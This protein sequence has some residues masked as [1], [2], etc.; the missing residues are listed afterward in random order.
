MV[1]ASIKEK[2][3]IPEA[4]ARINYARN[5]FA[6]YV[7]TNQINREELATVIGKSRQYVDKL[8]AG[9]EKGVAAQINL[10]KLMEYTQFNGDNFY[11][12][13]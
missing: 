6:T 12:G 3:T 13:R 4:W 2:L 10:Q 1:D 7:K 8:L 9:T 5:E 11:E